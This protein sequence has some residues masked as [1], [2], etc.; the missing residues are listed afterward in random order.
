LEE[1]AG[2]GPTVERPKAVWGL[3]HIAA[4]LLGHKRLSGQWLQVQMGK[5]RPV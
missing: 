3:E 4:K 2:P 1:S 5:L